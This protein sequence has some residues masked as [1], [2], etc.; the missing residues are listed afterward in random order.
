MCCRSS[1]PWQFKKFAA[2]S[3]L[4]SGHV[5]VVILNVIGRV[6]H[7][8]FLKITMVRSFAFIR[9]NCFTLQ[10]FGHA[11][12]ATLH[13]AK[14]AEHSIHLSVARL[15]TYRV[16]IT[17]PAYCPTRLSCVRKTNTSAATRQLKPETMRGEPLVFS[18]VRP[19]P[20]PPIP[21]GDGLGG[22]LPYKTLQSVVGTP[23]TILILCATS[24]NQRTWSKLEFLTDAK[25]P[26]GNVERD[27]SAAP[28]DPHPNIGGG[29]DNE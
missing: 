23:Y 29:V 17:V 19:P 15:T 26:T 21:F 12:P 1:A 22:G 6:F 28:F 13:N 20:P 18:S 3:H 25:N 27:C 7:I 10:I 5:R 9:E 4:F 16:R 2:Q 11:T 8:L 14:R 24:K